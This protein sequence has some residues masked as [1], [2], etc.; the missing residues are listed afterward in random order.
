M[1]LEEIDKFIFCRSSPKQVLQSIDD[2]AFS[3]KDVVELISVLI[4]GFIDDVVDATTQ[5]LKGLLW[6]F[7][8][9][10]SVGILKESPS[11]KTFVFVAVLLMS[12]FSVDSVIKL[13]F[14]LL[15]TIVDFTV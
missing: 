11:D 15:L 6:V 8:E 2:V 14:N 10:S 4:P 1:G 5:V 13:S 9:V 7:W 3:N 12:V